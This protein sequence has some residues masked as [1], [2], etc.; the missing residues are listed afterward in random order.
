MSIPAQHEVDFGNPKQHFSWA[1]KNMPMIA[2]I[3][4]VTHPGILESWSEHFWQCGF[5]HRD[6]L[7]SLADEDGNIHVSQLPQQVIKLQPP[8]RGQYTD[9]NPAARWVPVDQP[10][11]HPFVVQDVRKL[12]LQEQ[13][14][15]KDM[16]IETGV[17]K[18]ELPSPSMAEEFNEGV[19][20]G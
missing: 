3:G 18:V 11:V 17:V 20:G 16:L 19:A 7:E 12:T 6:Y 4:A 10:D 14:A 8:V 5:A 2:G 13:H 1:M 15:V 9:Y